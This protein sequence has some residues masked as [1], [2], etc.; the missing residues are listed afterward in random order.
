MGKEIGQYL[1]VFVLLFFQSPPGDLITEILL[2]GRINRG[3]DG[4]EWA[5]LYLSPDQFGLHHQ[6]KTGKKSD[7]T[8]GIHIYGKL[9]PVMEDDIQLIRSRSG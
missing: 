9:L 7:L 2:Q 4:K 8:G 5:F 6:I 1:S 3:P